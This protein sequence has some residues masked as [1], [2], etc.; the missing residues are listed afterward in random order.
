MFCLVKHQDNQPGVI[1]GTENRQTPKLNHQLNQYTSS[2]MFRLALF[3]F[4]K[5]S[6]VLGQ[7]THPDTGTIVSDHVSSE[8]NL[9]RPKILV[10]T[11]DVIRITPSHLKESASISLP[12]TI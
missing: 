12:N 4:T 8:I 9:I 2:T 3:S 10:D 6:K 5:Y 11:L 7:I 1:N